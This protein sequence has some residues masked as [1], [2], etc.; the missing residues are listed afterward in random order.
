MA[1]MGF[2]ELHTELLSLLHHHGVNTELLAGLNTTPPVIEFLTTPAG[3]RWKEAAREGMLPPLRGL[4]LGWW[5]TLYSDSEPARL[6]AEAG[7]TESLLSQ[8]LRGIPPEPMP[9]APPGSPS[10]LDVLREMRAHLPDTLIPTGWTEAAVEVLLVAWD[11]CGRRDIQTDDL[12]HALVYVGVS[13]E[14]DSGALGIIKKLEAEHDLNLASTFQPRM[15]LIGSI[16]PSEPR[17][18][19]LSDQADRIL[20]LARGEA[21]GLAGTGH[22]LWALTAIGEGNAHRILTAIGLSAE[23]IRPFLGDA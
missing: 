10:P 14:P 1:G 5:L 16:G 12:L 18:M 7:V 20:K 8:V 6:L 2:Q 22:L 15:S 23:R 3:N 11:L 21:V 4:L 19:R 9:T 17:E 13:M